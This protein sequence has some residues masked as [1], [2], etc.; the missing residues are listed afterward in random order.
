MVDCWVHTPEVAGSSPSMKSH[1]KITIS[2]QFLISASLHVKVTNRLLLLPR[3]LLRTA[4]VYGVV[5]G[6][7]PC[8]GPQ[9]VR[10]I[11]LQPSKGEERKDTFHFPSHSFRKSWSTQ[12]PRHRTFNRFAVCGVMFVILERRWRCENRRLYATRHVHLLRSSFRD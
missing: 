4:H 12:L 5:E 2:S 11:P 1:R 3:P 10:T 7:K 6:C 9:F 8:V